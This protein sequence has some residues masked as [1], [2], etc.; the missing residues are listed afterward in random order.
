[1][2]KILLLLLVFVFLIN[3]DD[4][5]SPP[6]YHVDLNVPYYAWIGPNYCTVAC[7]Q[8]W[9]AYDGVYVDQ[10]TIA[11]DVGA[12][13]NP[14]DAAHGVDLYTHSIGIVDMEEAT[15]ES[16]QD[17]CIAYSIACVN[18][19]VPSIIPFYNGQHAILAKGFDWH[20]EE[21][22]IADYMRY[23]D[24]DPSYGPSLEVT[25]SYLKSR[26]TP[27][28]GMYYVIT[29]IS[30]HADWGLIGY[31]AFIMEKGTFYG[32]PVNYNPSTN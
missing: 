24:P 17:L 16:K 27:A 28:S 25:G 3:C 8:M 1:M 12:P 19:K 23:H 18:D 11:S 21:V 6:N 10:A 31:A 32:G 30:L 2:K 15:S 26:F 5:N 22:P 29:G 4:D 7:I 13:T 20:D 14:Y 9:A